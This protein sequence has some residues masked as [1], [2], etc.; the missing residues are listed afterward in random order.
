ML[1]L[2]IKIFGIWLFSP[3]VGIPCS[4]HTNAEQKSPGE[5]QNIRHFFRTV[6]TMREK[7]RIKLLSGCRLEV[8]TRL[9]S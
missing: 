8:K 7:C 1:F 3:N 6:K 5:N 9:D 4:D 2:R